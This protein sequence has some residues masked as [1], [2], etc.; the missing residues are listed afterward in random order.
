MSAFTGSW[1][2]V[3]PSLD[4]VRLSVHSK[5]SEQGALAALLTFSGVAWEG[6]GR[7]DGD[8]F[9]ADMA[10][11]HTANPTRVLVARARDAGT[12]VVQLRSPTGAP[13][14]LTFVRDD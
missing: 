8:A 3:T 10:L 11:I 2:S 14:E 6:S 5:S 4:F 1:R 7:I 13:L 12:L 9:V